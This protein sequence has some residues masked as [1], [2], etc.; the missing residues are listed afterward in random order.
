MSDTSPD[1]A[2]QNA[3]RLTKAGAAMLRVECLPSPLAEQIS[4]AVRM[5]VIGI[6]AGA[7]T[8]GQVLVLHDMPGCP[9]PGAD[10][11][12]WVIHVGAG[13]YPVGAGGEYGGGEG[14]GISGAEHGYFGLRRLVEGPSF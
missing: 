2:M 11:G 13:E 10:P 1:Q 5:P 9:W 8:G 12:L 4:Q 6:G 7:G 14:W 3:G